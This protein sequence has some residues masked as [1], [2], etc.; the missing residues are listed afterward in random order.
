MQT[1]WIGGLDIGGTKIAACLASVDGP[2]VRLTAP[3]PKSGAVSA[4]ADQAV[5]L[6]REACD[7]A[8]LPFERIERIGV[9]SCGPFV[10]EDGLVALATPNICGGISGD[11]ELPNDWQSVP[12]ERVLRQ[13]FDTVTI[14]NDCVAALQAERTFGS[15]RDQAN[16]AYATWSTGIGFG[17]CVDG[18]LLHGKSGNAGHAGHMLLAE[19]PSAQCG[20]GNTGDVEGLIGGHNLS[21]Q[22]DRAPADIFNAAKAGDESARQIA[23]E[24][25]KWFGRALYNLTAILDL[26]TIV[27]GG[28]IWQHHGDWLKPLVMQEIELRLPALTTGVTIVEAGL[29]KYVADIGA[30]C[31]AMPAHWCAQWHAREAWRGFDGLD[32]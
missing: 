17:L 9:S 16:C 28:S 29:G 19:K 18:R 32:S 30:L 12:L 15:V 25:A 24:S 6:L 13:H 20:C 22:Y 27:V 14:E 10:R 3:T 5:A 23:R 7:A 4:P 8:G 26:Q 31:L 1:P 21:V 11:T 2:L